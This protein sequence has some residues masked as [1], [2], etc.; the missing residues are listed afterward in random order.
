MFKTV[1]LSTYTEYPPE[2]MQ[3]RAA[4]YR[5]LMQRRRTVR[6]YSTRAVPRAPAQAPRCRFRRET[7]CGRSPAR[8]SAHDL[9]VLSMDI[10]APARP[11][12]RDP[13]AEPR[14]TRRAVPLLS[15]GDIQ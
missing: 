9:G 10:T 3:R 11:R 1:P 8:L 13:P 4:D 2:E 7:R 14:F 6:E 12:Q 15:T 5:A